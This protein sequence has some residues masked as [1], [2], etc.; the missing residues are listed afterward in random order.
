MDLFWKITGGILIA[1]V[2]GLTLRKDLSVLLALAVCAMGL[3]AALEYISPVLDLLRRMETLAAFQGDTMGI[4]IK[5]MG[6]GFVTEIAAMICLDSGNG[7]LAKLIKSLGFIT[8]AWLA[9]P[10]FEAVITLLERILGEL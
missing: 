3:T 9:I 4:L 6:I 8:I 7:S 5:T 1:S 2:L 10:L